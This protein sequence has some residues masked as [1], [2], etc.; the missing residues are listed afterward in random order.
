MRP[1]TVLLKIISRSCL[2][3]VLLMAWIVPAQAQQTT[4]TETETGWTC[5]VWVHVFGEG[6]SFTF[7]LTEE[8]DITAKTFTSMTCDDWDNA[9]HDYA[10]DPHLWLY[11]VDSDGVLTEIAEDDDGHTEVNSDRDWETF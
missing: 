11:S 10:A 4:C 8:T 7:T 3:L 1:A 9:P 6:P 5:T 2:A